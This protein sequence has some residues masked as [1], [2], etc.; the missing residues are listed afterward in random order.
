[1]TVTRPRIALVIPTLNEAAAIGGV[2][3]VVP[4]DIVDEII[5]A[6]SLSTD[7]TAEIA[8]AAGA[9]VVSLRERGYGRACRAGA[10]AARDCAIIVFLDGDGSDCPELI[11]QLVAPIIAD[12]CDFVIGSRT[13]GMRQ[14]G[15]MNANQII[16]GRVIGA[17]VQL[18]YGVRYSDMCPFRAI[19]RDA[20][21]RLGMREETYGWNLEMQMRA[22]RAGLRII[23]LPVTHR[24]RAGG[25]SKVS[26][27][28]RGTVRAGSK[29]VATFIRIALE[30]RAA[31]RI[32]I[33]RSEGLPR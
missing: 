27:N 13:R 15:S 32:S 23:E 21:M 30:R 5:V 20:L 6:D 1:L 17:A 19:R 28:L 22:A 14:P 2:L 3:A 10:E 11:P 16:A 4:R 25:A 33:S 29:I 31:A 9:R 24:R 18:L 8:E 12:D 7:G 26:G